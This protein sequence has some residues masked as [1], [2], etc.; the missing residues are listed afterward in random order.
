MLVEPRRR[1]VEACLSSQDEGELKHACV[2]QAQVLLKGSSTKEMNEP[3]LMLFMHY[4]FSPALLT[5]SPLRS[6][7]G[8]SQR[9][10]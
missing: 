3:C 6:H 2:R 1:R 4:L 10:E 8:W 9:D 7:M 5:T